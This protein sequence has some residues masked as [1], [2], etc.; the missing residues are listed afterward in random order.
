[1]ML[2]GFLLKV[3]FGLFAQKFS[4]E[5]GKENEQMPQ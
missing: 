4:V 1:M 2:I 5:G 3:H